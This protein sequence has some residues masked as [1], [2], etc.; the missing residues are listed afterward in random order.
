MCYHQ[1]AD[2]ISKNISSK[3]KKRQHDRTSKRNLFI[4]P[5]FSLI[6]VSFFHL[7]RLMWTKYALNIIQ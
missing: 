5:S 2:P 6:F 4:S 7:I 3:I 1:L